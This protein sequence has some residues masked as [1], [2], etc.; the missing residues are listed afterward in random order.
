MNIVNVLLMSSLL[1]FIKT[2]RIE[3]MFCVKIS[4]PTVNKENEKRDRK[5]NSSSSF[6]CHVF[7][8]KK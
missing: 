1:S 6:S 8:L 7:T 3:C 4:F 5:L 2:E